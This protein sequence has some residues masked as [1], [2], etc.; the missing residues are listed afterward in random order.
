LSYLLGQKL[1]IEQLVQVLDK[2]YWP[3]LQAVVTTAVLLQ[4]WPKRQ[5]VHEEAPSADQKLAGQV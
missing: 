5:G 2:K 4:I 3:L 1:P